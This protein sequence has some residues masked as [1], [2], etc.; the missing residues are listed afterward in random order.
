MY[1]KSLTVPVPSIKKKF[2]K[3]L[4]TFADTPAAVLATF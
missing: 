3:S 4:M 1:I 2:T